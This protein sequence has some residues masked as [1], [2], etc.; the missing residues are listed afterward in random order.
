MLFKCFGGAEAKYA[1]S[2]ALARP[3]ENIIYGVACPSAIK[4]RIINIS[5]FSFLGAIGHG[6]NSVVFQSIY[7]PAKIECVLKIYMK[8]RLHSDEIH[9]IHREIEIHSK[10]NHANI[11]PLYAVFQDTKAFYLVLEYCKEGDLYNKL[12][13]T[14]S[15]HFE[16]LAA[17]KKR[18]L[19]PL[20]YAVKYLHHNKIIHRDVKPENILI[21]GASV[22]L[23]D[24]GLSI[25]TKNERV[26]SLVGTPEY[27]CPEIINEEIDKYS[28]KIDIWC[29]GIL[30]YECLNGRTP[31]KREDERKTFKAILEGV[32]KLPIY[33]SK[34]AALVEFFKKTLCIEPSHRVNINQLIEIA[35]T[36]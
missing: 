13:K 18:V 30:V 7:R 29:I 35:A 8:T 34:N 2:V 27:L 19:M 32:Y 14:P 12:T 24:I 23:C 20:L 22:K 16:D 26:K 28:E 17:F 21:N 4:N 36:I 5:D 9:R 10:L 15:G 1:P 31:F 33:L 25:C 6:Q 11:L 3:P